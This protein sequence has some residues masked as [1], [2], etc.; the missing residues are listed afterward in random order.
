MIVTWS[1][2]AD[3][4][5]PQELLVRTLQIVRRHPWWLAR[6]KLAIDALQCE[7][8]K[9]P[10]RI[11]DAGCGWGTNLDA[12][13]AAGYEATGLDISRQILQAIDRPGRKLLE[14]DLTQD[15][16]ANAGTFDGL[17]ALDV[18]EHLDDDR[19]AIRRMAGLLRPGGI[20]VI[21]VPAR[22]DLFSEF[23][24]VQ[25]HRRRYLPE[26][27][28]EVVPGSGL[29]IR[30]IFWWGQWMVPVLRRMRGKPTASTPGK[31]AKTYADYLRL[32]PWPGPL[33]MQFL[34]G[35]E[36]GRALNGKLKTGTSLF[37]VVSKQQ[38]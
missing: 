27:L 16:P 31:P 22:P 3:D 35:L 37:A 7:G 17:L 38:R 14:A 30:R 9:P 19:A 11:I 36:R 12:L 8:L 21:S 26:S 5:M 33:V 25:G 29:E 20:G 24:E 13:E 4:Y 6:G 34:Y 32:P 10:A 23:D 28:R 1:K 18:I 2:G 15:L